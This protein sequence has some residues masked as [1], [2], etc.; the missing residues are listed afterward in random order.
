M[1]LSRHPFRSLLLCALSLLL[2]VSTGC[3]TANETAVSPR[4]SV[5]FFDTF[6]TVITIIGYA[7]DE[8]TF[9][10]TTGEA[11]AMFQ[12]L[13]KLYDGYNE[14][15]GVHNV[16]TLNHEAA[17]QPI[18]VEQELMDL[19]LFCRERQPMTSGAVNIALGSVLQIWH[20]YREEGLAD[21]VHAQLPPME[22]LR[23]A[24]E[25]TRLESLVLDPAQGTVAF[26][27]PLLQLDLGAVAKGY[28]A[29]RVAQLLLASPMPSFI[30]SAG[31]NVRVGNPP[32]DGERKAWGIGIQDPRGDVFSDASSD[33][34]ETFFIANRS[35]VTSGDYQRYYLVEGQA[36]HHLIDP[37][38]L[39]PGTYYQAVTIMAEDSGL[40]DLLSTAAFLLPL[41]QSRALIAS[42]EG[43]EAL[44]VLPDG[45]VEMT[46]GARV[47]AK[48]AGATSLIQK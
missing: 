47:F 46:E 33:L 18:P 22:E 12:R 7:P 24:A 35:L 20:E 9:Q 37:A 44:W 26:S 39:M 4:F 21:I 1:R 28:A 45:S 31:G 16:Y 43:V 6:D 3:A 41:E 29:E 2:T 42:L 17:N 34:K 10:Q 38:T 11:H 30:I 13:H 19:L 25:H 36:Y 14:Y 48:S 8:A 27:D 23:R 5:T 40:A 32:L 15:E